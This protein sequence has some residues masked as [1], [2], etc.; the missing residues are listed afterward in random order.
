MKDDKKIQVSIGGEQR[1]YAVIAIVL[2]NVLLLVVNM[3]LFSRHLNP[4][5]KQEEEKIAEPRMITLTDKVQKLKSKLDETTA[6]AM[7]L[8]ELREEFG[9]GLNTPLNIIGSE[10]R[11]VETELKNLSRQE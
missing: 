8:E 7:S 10:L 4:A 9:K 11:E 6:R 3:V 1:L 5:V 2:L